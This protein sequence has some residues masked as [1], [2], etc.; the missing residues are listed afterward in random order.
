V[1]DDTQS[2]GGLKRYIPA[3]I[4]RAVRQR[5]GFGCVVC[6]CP[7]V[8]YDHFDPA[9]KDAES[10]DANGITLL[11][12]TCH[13][14]KNRKLLSNDEVRRN[15]ANPRARQNGFIRDAVF[16][17][18]SV[19]LVRFGGAVFL[20]EQIVACDD[21]ILFGFSAA[22]EAGAPVR[23]QAHLCDK[24]GRQLLEI[25]DN[26]WEAGVDNFDVETSSG[27][28]IRGA[29]GE[30]VLKIVFREP[31]NLIV[32]ERLHMAYKGYVIDADSERIECRNPRGGVMNMRIGVARVRRGLVLVPSDGTMI[33]GTA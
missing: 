23:L 17:G 5:C 32:V 6:G 11:C 7:I 26:V 3:D 2:Q 21:E 13:G 16:L 9:F 31:D 24:D 20:S 33:F 18:P 8:D 25:V 22:E 15:N 10:H 29:D 27:I 14:K 19:P 12:G 1:T 4:R 28:L 30:V